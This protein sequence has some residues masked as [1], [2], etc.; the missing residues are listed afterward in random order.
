MSE[1]DSGLSFHIYFALALISLDV[2]FDH[3]S[4]FG[5]VLTMFRATL[6][7]IP[8]GV[9]RLRDRRVVNDYW[10]E[11]GMTLVITLG[12]FQRHP[13]VCE[14]VSARICLVVANL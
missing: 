2:K 5:H 6:F 8:H 14:C 10:P 9:V 12:N 11:A 4:C 1:P 7:Y 3:V 13:C